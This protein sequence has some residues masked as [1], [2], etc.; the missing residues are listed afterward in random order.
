MKR[1]TLGELTSRLGGELKGDAGIQV[2]GVAPLHTAGPEHV[3][4]L[5]NPRY[6]AS[7]PTTGAAAVIVSRGTACEGVNLIMVDDPY[8][9]FAKAMEVFYGEPYRSTGVSELAFIHPGAHIGAEPSIHPFAVVCEGAAVGDR[10]TLMSGVY[11]GPGAAVGDDTILHPHVVLEKEVRV[12]K[13]VVVHAGTV[14]GS[15]G[16]GFARDGEGH[17]KIIQA[18]TVVVEDDVEIGA[19]CTIDRAVMGQTVIGAGSKLD[20]LIQVGHNAVIGRHCIIVSQVGISGSTELE[21]AV[22]MAGQSGVAGHLTIGRGAVVLAKSAV[23]KNVPAGAQV[24]GI[25]AVD[26]DQWRKTT[27]ILGKLDNLR[28]KV[29]RLESEMKRITGRSREEER[30]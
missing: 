15:D 10:V 23:F 18:G 11:V 2:S 12:G 7:L 30:D 6:A 14:I 5:S 4:F 16:F 27:A 20:N 3:S 26:G 1:I 17:R 29:A 21:D 8:L 9:G 28:R 13:G 22:T 25:P 19:G 24:G